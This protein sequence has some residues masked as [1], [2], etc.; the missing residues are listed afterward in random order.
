MKLFGI[1][2]KYLGAV[3]YITFSTLYLK[4]SINHQTLSISK[5]SLLVNMLKR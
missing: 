2:S 4:A 5:V 3:L 1:L